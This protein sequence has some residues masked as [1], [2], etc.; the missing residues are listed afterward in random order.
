MG[1]LQYMSPKQRHKFLAEKHEA[2]LRARRG[3]GVSYLSDLE[4]KK[5]ELKGYRCY[6]FEYGKME[7]R[8]LHVAKGQVKEMRKNGCYARVVAN[9]CYNIKGCKTYSV[10]WRRRK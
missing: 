2:G 9:P 10:L 1:H 8:F 7:T 6:V 3:K 4:F 5:L